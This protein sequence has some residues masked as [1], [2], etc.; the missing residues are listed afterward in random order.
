MELAEHLRPTDNQLK[1]SVPPAL[2]SVYR[3][4]YQNGSLRTYKSKEA[5]AY[6]EE[7]AWLMKHIKPKEGKVRLKLNFCFKRDRDIDSGLKVLLDALSGYIYV[8]DKQIVE[9]NVIKQIIPRSGSVAPCVFVEYEYL[10]S[11][12]DDEPF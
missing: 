7:V 9:L 4:T 12:S 2:N 6:A 5:K 11:V 3:S 1:L 8:D 10:D